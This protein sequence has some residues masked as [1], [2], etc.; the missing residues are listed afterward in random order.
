[1]FGIRKLKTP[2]YGEPRRNTT[3]H[4]HE[5]TEMSGQQQTNSSHSDNDTNTKVPT[6]TPTATPVNTSNSIKTMNTTTNS[7]TYKNPNTRTNACSQQHLP[8][9][10]PIP[11]ATNATRHETKPFTKPKR[12][13]RRTKHNP[14]RVPKKSENL[15]QPPPVHPK[16]SRPTPMTH[17]IYA[18]LDPSQ[19]HFPDTPITRTGQAPPSFPPSR[20]SIEVQDR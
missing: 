11:T 16:L 5:M 13:S 6:T 18:S 1:M 20:P 10:T 14:P 12:P 9:L 2:A 7:T 19:Y 8:T 4:N 3:P 17:R 15:R